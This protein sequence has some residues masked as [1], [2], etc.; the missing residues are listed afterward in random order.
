MKTNV[1]IDGFNLYYGALKGTAFRWLNVEDLCRHLLPGQQI[2]RIRYF[3]APVSARPSDPHGPI[4]QQIYL[5]ALATLP[6]I[7]IHQ[8]SFLAKTKYR[9]LVTDGTYVWIHDTEEKG[10]DVNLA[11]YL[12]HDGHRN[13][14]E[15]AVVISNDSDLRLPIDLVVS[16]LGFPVGLLNPHKK[17]ARDLQGIATFYKSIR[18]GVLSASQ[19]PATL[20]D[21]NGTF[22]K[23]PSW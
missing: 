13:D 16:D 19:F 17:V 9:P 23:P 20:S 14:Y 18:A 7:T 6:S 10:S 11:T 22:T 8:G 1:Y 15:Q 21:S 3:T 4:R 2:H 5:R 12:L